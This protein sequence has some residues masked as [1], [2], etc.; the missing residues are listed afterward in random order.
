MTGK[1]Q[2]NNEH[3]IKHAPSID[4]QHNR[5][6]SILRKN[7]KVSPFW[8]LPFIALCIGAI[9]F[10]QIVK[11][12]GKS[13]K[14]TFSNGSGLVADKTPIRYQGLQI[15]VVKKVN[16]TDNMQK[17]EVVANIYPE[18]TGV[19]RQNTRFWVV[20]PSVSL[21]G[22]SGLDSLVSGNYITLQP[23]DG[24]SADEFIAQEK[25]PITQVSPG[26]LL[27]HLTSDDLGSISLGASVY[28]KKLPVGKIYDYRFN[29]NNKVEIDVVIDKEY[30]RFVKKD[31]RF[32][33]I[34]GVNASITQA[35][36]NFNME[37]VNAIV[38][39]AVSF[40]SPTDSPNAVENDYYTLYANLQA[41]KRGIEVDVN[42]PTVAGLEA[43]RSDVYYQ[44]HKI[45]V[46]SALSTVENN[47][48]IL[49][50]R[51]LID[52]NQASLLK[53]GSHIVLRNKKPNLADLTEP[54]RF[55]RGD[56]FEIIPGDGEEKLQFDVIKENELLLKAPNTLVIKLTAP[57]SYGIAEGQNVY[58]NNIPIGEIV[59]QNIDVNG[60]E[61][62]IAIA[63]AYRNLIN[64][65]TLFVAASNFDV[66][67]GIDGIRF[68]AANPEKWLQGGIRIIA[69]KGLGDALKTYPLYKDAQ[70]AESGI[71]GNLVEPSITLKTSNLPSISKDSLVLY[72]QYEVGKIINITPQADHFDV[73]V[74]IYPRY[75]HLLTDKSLFWVESAAQ[76]D[77]TPKGISIQSTPI[78]RSLKGAISFDNSGSSQNKTLY[79]N[80]LRAKS[81]GQIITLFADDA[82]NLTKGMSLRYLGLSVGEI[83]SVTLDAKSKKIIAK[84]LVNP[85]YMSM[86]A[87]EGSLFKIISPQIS[88]GGIENLDS[89][90]QPYIDVEIGNGKASTRFD[91]AQTTPSRNKFTN[92][93]PFI[94]ET[95]DA[96][97]LTEGSPVF[98]RGIEVGAVL[99]LALNSLG[100][101]V[102]IHIA[103]SPKYRH[104]VRKNSEFW[105]SSGYN[106]SLGWKGA[107]FN[108]GSVQQLLK[109][110]IS[111]ST[112]SGTTVQQQASENQRFLLQTKRP[113][114][115]PTWNSGA[116]PVTP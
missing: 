94:L 66:N 86:I 7:R 85:N 87:K 53:T 84:A 113:N 104:L 24:N 92:G 38:Q 67:F 5:I 81:A 49:K 18:A 56:Y 71:T 114:E 11:E 112:P 102:L 21:A 62:E 15:G 4:S 19:L 31:S 73:D 28:F 100:D 52:P 59:K 83:E 80:E 46:L 12:Q 57:E 22:I 27:I 89:L 76:I 34:S 95:N 2:P 29:E 78:A 64:P 69:K 103:I 33:N 60:V 115:A 13:I 68:N 93:V 6:Q 40:D 1:Q 91:L 17:V 116:L 77:I 8:L 26:D 61:Y 45:G 98:Y 14:I 30:A 110:G 54:Q 109:G 97:N 36:L 96:L 106:F 65:N 51:L 23:G 47:E 25:G 20:E 16:F 37:S 108:T 39:G 41:A 43:G 101:R 58:Y 55:F 50:G 82:T 74:Y 35:G 99:K 105:I 90:L 75:K 42:I 111:F 79:P 3:S 32:W 88:A 70:N 10:F 48:K 107:E 63:A 44:E 72:R 9:L